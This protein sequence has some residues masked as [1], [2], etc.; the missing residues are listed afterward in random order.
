MTRF[1]VEEGGKRRAFKASEGVLTIGSGERAMLKLAS[2]GVADVH[3]ELVLSAGTVKLRPKPGVVPPMVGGASVAGEML[4]PSGSVVTIGEASISVQDDDAPAA[5]AAPAPAA[6]PKQAAPVAAKPS[7]AA[8]TGKAKAKAPIPAGKKAPER[9]KE[10]WQR[11]NKEIFKDKSGLKPAHVLMILVPVAILAF[12]VINKFIGK[13]PDTAIAGPQQ[14]FMARRALEGGMWDQAEAAIALIEDR[15]KLATEYQA[16]LIEIEQKIVEGRKTMEVAAANAAGDQYLQVMLKNFESSRL[17]AKVERPVVRV[18]LKRIAEFEKRWP[19]HPEMEWVHRKKER[20]A[21]MVDLNKPATFEDIDF[22]VKALTWDNPRNYRE[23]FS[24][25]NRW[26]ETAPTDDRG[27]GLALL[28]KLIKER[29]AWFEDRMLEAR[30]QLKK[31]QIGQAIQ[32]L[33][34]LITYSGDNAMADKAAAELIKFD[35]YEGPGNVVV[36]L[37]RELRGYRRTLPDY[38]KQMESNRVLAE[39]MKEHP[40]D[41]K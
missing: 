10:A 4:L 14:V 23:A 18:F 16:E 15:S 25:T 6:A 3:A 24:L 32:W 29:D 12:F 13:G 8:G 41:D 28:D 5:A 39:W 38:W 40:I 27:K 31:G 19:N 34:I 21:G 2:P 22:E 37:D 11:S 7:A 26:L 20:Y 1:V 35:G 9:E 30:H 33:A 36:H 17:G